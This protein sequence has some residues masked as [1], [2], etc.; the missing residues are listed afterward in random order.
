MFDES[1]MKSFECLKEKLV[2]ALIIMAHDCSLPFEVMCDASGV[3]L[4]AVLGP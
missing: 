3:A 1:S 2:S 4:G